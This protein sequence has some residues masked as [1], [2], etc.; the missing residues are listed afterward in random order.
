MM[1]EY[2]TERGLRDRSEISLVMPLP[3]PDPA[4]AGTR[5][6][7]CSRPSPSAASNG[8]PTGWCAGSTPPARSR[9]SPTAP[10][11]RTTCSSACPCTAH[12]RSS[13]SRRSASTAGS[14]SNPM[15]LETS[16]PDVY[17]VGDV[18]SVGTPKAGVFAEGQARWSPTRSSL[19]TA[20]ASSTTAAT[21]ATAS[22]TS[23]SATTRSPAST[24]RS[25]AAKTAR[26]S[27]EGPSP[28]YAADKSEF[29]SSRI[30]R[31]FGHDWTNY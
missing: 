6:R 29:G 23:S 9:C 17:A 31:W 12:R 2:L 13:R 11:C 25:S 4:V 26:G 15:T 28:V 18:T 8:I 21:T 16:F 5:R 30:R 3:V 20:A 14:R 7:P 10:R 24:S 27:L 1:H 19:A 22:A